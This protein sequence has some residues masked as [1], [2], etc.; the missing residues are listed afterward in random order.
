MTTP[1][2]EATRTFEDDSNLERT[3]QNMVASGHAVEDKVEYDFFGFAAEERW[4]FPG[5]DSVPEEERQYFIVAKM[6]EGKKA[7]FQSKT[8]NDVRIQRTTGDARFR[9]DPSTER[10]TLI[11]LSVTGARVKLRNKSTN[12]LEW[13][14][15]DHR[16]LLK[17][18][19]DNGNPDHVQKLEQFIRNL[20]PWMTTEM[21]VEEIDKEIERLEELKKERKEAETGN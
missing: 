2:D 4:Y 15:G 20:N 1:Q 17:R 10:H 19:L 21:D 11:T 7:E 8:T 3:H 13:H 12:E 18:W 16:Q 9:M 14:N 6:N 5:Q